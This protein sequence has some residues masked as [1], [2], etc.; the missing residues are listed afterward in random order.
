[1]KKQELKDEVKRLQIISNNQKIDLRFQVRESIK[2]ELL[3]RTGAI[4][5]K[6]II[7]AWVTSKEGKKYYE[8]VQRLGH[9]SHTRFQTITD[10][11]LSTTADY[12]GTKMPLKSID[13]WVYEGQSPVAMEPKK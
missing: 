6:T 5:N 1:M 8:P 10:L 4:P 13:V 9:T 12:D 7:G 2:Y 3:W 11:L